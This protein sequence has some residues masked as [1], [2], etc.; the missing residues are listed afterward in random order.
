VNALLRAAPRPGNSVTRLSR[1]SAR[2]I[3]GPWN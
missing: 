1:F 2:T 3:A